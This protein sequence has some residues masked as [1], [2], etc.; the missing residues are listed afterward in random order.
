VSLPVEEIGEPAFD[1]TNRRGEDRGHDR[2]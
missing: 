2:R 1:F